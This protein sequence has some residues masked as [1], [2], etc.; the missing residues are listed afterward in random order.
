MTDNYTY[1]DAGF[2][3][4]LTKKQLPQTEVLEDE[5]S[6]N[7]A[8]SAGSENKAGISTSKDGRMTIDWN[9]LK[10][11]ISDGIRSRVVIGQFKEENKY[12]VRVIDSAGVT[13][14]DETY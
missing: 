1:E 9:N 4:F 3:K 11:T 5:S 14:L 6:L 13:Q 2:D 8:P 7:I 12:G 10:I